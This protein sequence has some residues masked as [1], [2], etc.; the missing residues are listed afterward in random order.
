MVKARVLYH[1]LVFLSQQNEM[2]LLNTCKLLRVLADGGEEFRESIREA[3]DRTLSPL[4]ETLPKVRCAAEP[5]P[6]V[7][8]SARSPSL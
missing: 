5:F 7:K 3:D 2:V 6:A 8:P 4:F 1:A